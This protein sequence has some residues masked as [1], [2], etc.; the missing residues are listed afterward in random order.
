M[1]WLPQFQVRNSKEILV[2]V[3]FSQ[4]NS[5][6][7]FRSW[8][9]NI[10]ETFTYIVTVRSTK[11]PDTLQPSSTHHWGRGHVN[12]SCVKSQYDMLQCY[13]TALTPKRVRRCTITKYIDIGVIRSWVD[14]RGIH[15]GINNILQLLSWFGTLVYYCTYRFLTGIRL[16]YIHIGSHT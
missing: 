13:R 4:R 14:R 5:T 16:F 12:F 6:S 1:C 8:V 15:N 11:G 3:L 7:T 10:T 9:A 2:V